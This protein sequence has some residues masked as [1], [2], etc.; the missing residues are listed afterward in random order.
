M[1]GYIYS[2]NDKINDGIKY[3]VG[4]RY[5][6]HINFQTTLNEIYVEPNLRLSDY[7]VFKIKIN[8]YYETIYDIYTKDFKITEE[9]N[10]KEISNN[11]N[12]YSSKL[13]E[14][15]ALKNK[16]EII[17]DQW[18][19]SNK[20]SNMKNLVDSGVHKYLDD[21]IKLQDDTLLVSIIRK[22]GRNKD[23]E[24]VKKGYN[25]QNTIDEIFYEIENIG[26]PEDLDFFMKNKNYLDNKALMCVI[27]AH[28]RNKD[29]KNIKKITTEEKR[30]IL[31]SG[32]DKYLDEVIKNEEVEFYELVVKHG[33]KKDIPVLINNNKRTII[34]ELIYN[35]DDNCLDILMD[36]FIDEYN[37]DYIKSILL[38]YNRKKDYDKIAKSSLSDVF[39]NN[40]DENYKK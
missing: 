1:I 14:I 2:K 28:G 38:K 37:V 18:L 10:Y 9:I 31:F 25:K 4:K 20:F 16:D 30:M 39:D 17:F 5:L 36:R 32:I 11:Y 34:E 40:L 27:L 29:I 35:G 26:R 22:Y 8:D 6:C 19:N 33:R 23:I 21:L 3:E 7:K 15:A 13:Q 12:N 24:F